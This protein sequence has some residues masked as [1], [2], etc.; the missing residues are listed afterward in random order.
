MRHIKILLPLVVFILLVIAYKVGFF[1]DFL[2]KVEYRDESIKTVEKTAHE[3]PIFSEQY[4]TKVKTNKAYGTIAVIDLKKVAIKSEAGKYIEKRIAEINDLSKKDLLDLETKI[5]S[6]D[7]VKASETDTRKIEDM[8]LI[9]YDMVRTKRYQISEAYKKAITILESE[10]KKAVSYVA[11]QKGI[12]VVLASDAVI[13]RNNDCA[14]ITSQ[15]ITRVNDICREVSV[16][17]NNE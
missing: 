17:L 9:L 8:Q 7:T 15:V 12:R 2:G 3:Q 4:S 10:I 16:V 5:K 13:Y 14:D 6:M 1:E 11:E